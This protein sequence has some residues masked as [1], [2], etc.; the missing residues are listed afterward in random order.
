MGTGKK[1]T[2][3]LPPPGAKSQLVVPLPPPVVESNLLEGKV[4]PDLLFEQVAAPAAVL[5]PTDLLDQQ[6][7]PPPPPAGGVPLSAAD[8]EKQLDSL[9]G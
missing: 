5:P 9:L 6:A 3:L 7:T 4:E 1:I 2:P 8:F